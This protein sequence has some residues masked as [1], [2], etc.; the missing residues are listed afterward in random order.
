VANQPLIEIPTP[1]R[2][3][4]AEV[5]RTEARDCVT[6]ASKRG[7]TGVGD[8]M[9]GVVTV[10]SA[11]AGRNSAGIKDSEDAG[12]ALAGMPTSAFYFLRCR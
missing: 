1:A 12:S 3:R 6:A 9:D 11:I 4:A 7:V 5:K 8:A 10:G 2:T